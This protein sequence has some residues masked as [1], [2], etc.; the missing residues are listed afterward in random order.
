MITYLIF[1]KGGLHSILVER[2]F[3]KGFVDLIW[4]I[5]IDQDYV[6]VLSQILCG[7]YPKSLNPWLSGCLGL[8]FSGSGD[9]ERKS[10][11]ISQ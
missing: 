5:T 6:S 1:I 2:C 7:L 9:C 4:V 8:P 3:S 10:G 11:G